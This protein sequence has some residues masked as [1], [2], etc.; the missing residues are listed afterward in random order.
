MS[1]SS[2]KSKIEQIKSWLEGRKT[3]AKKIA[4]KQSRSDYYASKGRR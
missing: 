1:K 4:P 2:N 3:Q